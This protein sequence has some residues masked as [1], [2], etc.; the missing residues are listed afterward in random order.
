MCTTKRVAKVL[1]RMVIVLIMTV[2]VIISLL[3]G[4]ITKLS[5]NAYTD[6]IQ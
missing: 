6:G 5:F 1:A 3:F 2:F 4:T